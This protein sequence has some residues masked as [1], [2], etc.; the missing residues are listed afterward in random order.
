MSG[1]EN[2]R[3]NKPG[4]VLHVD[5]TRAESRIAHAMLLVEDPEEL[6]QLSEV[7]AAIGKSIERFFGNAPRP[8]VSTH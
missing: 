6:R 5:L 4:G 3:Q 1:V 2:K 8:K 7:H